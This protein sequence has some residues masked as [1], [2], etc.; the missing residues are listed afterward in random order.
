MVLVCYV[1]F[2]LVGFSHAFRLETNQVDETIRIPS[3]G[4]STFGPLIVKSFG[5]DQFQT[6]LFNIPFGAVQLVATMGGAW[7]AMVWKVK[8]PVLVLLS[9]P[10]IIGCVVLLNVSHTP[11]HRGV[12]LVGYYLVSHWD[13][14]PYTNRTFR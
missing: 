10:P 12:L 1:V 9:I 5:F 3:G 6:I 14:I 11:D 8:G 2:S 13:V 7:L 4:I